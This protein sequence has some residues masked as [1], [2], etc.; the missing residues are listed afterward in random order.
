MQAVHSFKAHEKNVRAMSYD[1]IEQAL[2]T[3]SFDR[4]CQV[5]RESAPKAEAV[6]EG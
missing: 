4:K 1:L 6:S 3:G 5:W 2:V